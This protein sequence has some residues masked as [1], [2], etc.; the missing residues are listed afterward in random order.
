M[1]EQVK[2]WSR[3]RVIETLPADRKI[4]FVSDLHLG[5]GTPSDCFF[6]KDRHLIALIERVEAEGA[7]LVVNGDAIDFHQAWSFERVLRA[8]KALLG[9]LSRLGRE[10]RLLYIIG[11]HDYD[12]TLFSD[13]M[14]FRVCDEL[15]VGTE[16]LV[17]HGYE[18]DPF[19]SELLESGQWETKI[20]HAIERYLNTWIRIPLA[21]FYTVPNRL[22]VWL[23]HKLALG[24]LLVKRTG[25]RLVGF[26]DLADEILAHLDFAAWSNQGDAMGIFRPAFTEA[27]TGPWRFVLCGH[28]H[29][30]GIVRDGER[31]YA[32]TGSWTFASSQYIVWDGHDLRCYDWLTGREYG[33][34]LYRPMLD[35]TLYER[36]FL[37]WWREN[38]MG[39][40]RFREGEERRGRLHGWES[41]IRDHESLAQLRPIPAFPP[42]PTT[43]QEPPP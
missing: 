27:R 36:G 34:E 25:G 4:W 8:H 11:N 15:H 22:L 30:P 2:G 35:G 39:W 42:P 32:N 18:Y 12:I 23:L 7:T 41:Y 13:V 9:A 28:S 33:D 21:E 20:H 40:L 37:Q 26:E 17:R 5:D 31:G 38:Y 6:G 16:I 1:H 19:I 43:R 24:A 10:G 29:L 14:S 3:P